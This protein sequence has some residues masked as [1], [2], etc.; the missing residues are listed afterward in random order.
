MG[1][2]VDTSVWIDV[3]RKVWILESI[4][5]QPLERLGLPSMAPG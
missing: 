1:V 4:R 2:I 3:E 5:F